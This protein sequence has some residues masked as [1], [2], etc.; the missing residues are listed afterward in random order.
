M[1]IHGKP[2]YRKRPADYRMQTYR[3]S[4][5]HHRIA[6]VLSALGWVKS[7]PFYIPKKDTK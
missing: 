2:N 3:R 6:L 4:L 7:G 5:A 1:K